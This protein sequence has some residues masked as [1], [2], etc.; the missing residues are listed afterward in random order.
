MQC[1]PEGAGGLCWANRTPH[2]PGGSAG[3]ALGTWEVQRSPPTQD[4]A[5]LREP[6]GGLGSASRGRA[7]SSGRGGL[8]TAHP[9]I[10]EWGL[11]AAR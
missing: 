8:S 3:A 7:R 5:P 1:L 11:R 4:L 6:R 9:G 2:S 10:Q